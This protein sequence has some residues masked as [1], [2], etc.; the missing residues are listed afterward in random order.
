MT[1]NVF[2]KMPLERALA[3]T[4]GCRVVIVGDVR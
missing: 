4:G 1:V 2:E 3:I